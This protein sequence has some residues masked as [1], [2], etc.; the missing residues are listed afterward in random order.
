MTAS[1]ITLLGAAAKPAPINN[2]C[3]KGRDVYVTQL[4]HIL[5]LQQEQIIV[6][7]HAA[8]YDMRHLFLERFPITVQHCWAFGFLNIKQILFRLVR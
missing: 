2:L 3:H 6:S 8:N 7:T 1:Q 4:S 5:V